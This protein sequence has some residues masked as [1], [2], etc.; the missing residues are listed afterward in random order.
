MW[1]PVVPIFSVTDHPELQEAVLVLP[2][3]RVYTR[4]LESLHATTPTSLSS[5]HN[6]STLL[7]LVSAWTSRHDSSLPKPPPLRPEMELALAGP[8]H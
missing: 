1:P 6:V 3:L 5:A 4:T 8:R 2:G 7:N